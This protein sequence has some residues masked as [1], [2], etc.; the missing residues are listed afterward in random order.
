MNVAALVRG[1]TPVAPADVGGYTR[2]MAKASL[3]AITKY[4]Y[5]ILRTSEVKDYDG[6]ANGLQVENRGGVTRIAAAVDAATALVRYAEASRTWRN[7]HAYD[8]HN[9]QNRRETRRCSLL[10]DV[11]IPRKTLQPNPTS[12]EEMVGIKSLG[13]LIRVPI[14]DG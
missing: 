2:R 10:R 4:C 8:G 12:T 5:R 14:P 1:R 11:P 3:A 9:H 6:A 7:E 13:D